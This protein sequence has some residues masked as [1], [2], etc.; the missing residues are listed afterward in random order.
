M[1][2]KHITL[3]TLTSLIFLPT[4]KAQEK[5]VPAVTDYATQVKTYFSKSENL[6]KNHTT[7]S[8]KSSP[9]SRSNAP[10]IPNLAAGDFSSTPAF[11]DDFTPP[12]NA[13]AQQWK[14]AT[15][16][17]NGAQM[18]PERCQPNAQ[19]YMVQTV[20]AGF[21]PLGGSMQTDREF[22]YGRW[23]ARVKASPVPGVLNSVFTKDWDDLTTPEDLHDGQKS[24]VD[25]ELLSSTFSENAG[26]VHLAIHLKKHVPLWHV[27]IPIDFNPS[28]EFHEWGFDILPDRVVWHVDGKLLFAWKY[29]EQ[30]RIDPAYEFF[31]N[32]W[33]SKNWILGPAA[34]DAHYEIDWVKFYPLQQ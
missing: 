10:E 26:E 3:L 25:I 18:S 9:F 7:A 34:E 5:T 17:Q 11:S 28:A 23:V 15:W 29:S 19:G 6:I 8:Q 4:T 13:K 1:N 30:Y 14:V 21:P 27:D 32:S 33:T 2:H 20:L 22:G 16:E 12:W 31:F 24:E